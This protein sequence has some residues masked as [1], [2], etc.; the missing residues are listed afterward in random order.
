MV[1]V[2]ARFDLRNATIGSLRDRRHIKA[3]ARGD[4]PAHES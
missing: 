4:A 1:L 2:A 3:V